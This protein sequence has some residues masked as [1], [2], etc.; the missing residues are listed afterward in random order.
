MPRLTFIASRNHPAHAYDHSLKSEY[1]DNHQKG[2]VFLMG[3]MTAEAGRL[4]V[5]S[6]LEVRNLSVRF[7]KVQIF[8]DLSFSV[9]RGTTLAII[10][11]N[12]SGKTMLFRA[13]LGAVPVKGTFRW[14][15]GVRIGYVPQKLDIARDVPIT[16]LDFLHARAALART[17]KEAIAQSLASVGLSSKLVHEPIG[18]FSGGQFQRLLV[19]FALMSSPNVLLM[20]E[21]AAGVDEAGR[22]FLAALVDRLQREQDLTVLQISHDL[23]EVTQRATTVL[24]LSRE[25]IQMGAPREVL[26]QDLLN[27]IY[28]VPVAFQR[29]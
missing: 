9:R 2:K 22:Q 1:H 21:P 4:G 3:K 23:T 10:G 6:V 12:G 24:V 14:A 27:K 28:G 26:T 15:S 20:D 7:G 16:G 8:E 11:P 29:R 18:N 17:S 5:E 25:H 13:L 19:A